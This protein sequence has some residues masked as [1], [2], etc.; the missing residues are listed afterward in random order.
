MGLAVGGKSSDS[1]EETEV[2]LHNSSDKV[3]WESR[4][5]ASN[6]MMAMAKR[7]EIRDEKSRMRPLDFLL[8][9]VIKF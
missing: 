3:E 8:S 9:F 5:D 1:C 4:H 2:P 7:A 6:M